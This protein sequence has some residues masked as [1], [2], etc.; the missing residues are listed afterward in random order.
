MK[1]CVAIVGPTASGKSGFALE[2]AA[3]LN[4]EILC[5]DSTT[6]YRGFDIGS[7]KPSKED[8]AKIKHH[9]L[10]VCEPTEPF[11]AYHFVKLAH[12]T[13]TEIQNRN[14]L[15][16]VVG[17]TY[18]YLKALQH[19]MYA[20]TPIPAEVIENIERE[21]FEDEILNTQK[22]HAELKKQDAE[23][24]KQVHPN[25]RYR[26]VRALAIL[27][28][29]KE[30]PSQLKVE[31]LSSD[32][33]GRYWLKYGMCLSRHTLN[34][35]IVRR[36]E[37]M[38]QQGLVEETKG[39]LEKH[40]QS[41]PLQSIGY[42]EAVQFLGRKITEK[43][44]RNEIIEKTRQLAKRQVTWLRSDPEVRYIDF[45]DLARVELEVSNLTFAVGG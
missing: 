19:G 2:L 39:L 42:A 13:I 30:K 7:S 10:D 28:T 8:Q 37:K 4:G 33:K 43:Q 1:I 45:R 15:P 31:P 22:M 32:Q 41:R 40:P 27:R 20:T 11:S 3:K 9:L 29:S 21:F 36:A 23:A 34:Q 12:E 16:I 26:L 25:D 5:M 18:F 17:G 35:A 6:V 38:I 24:A 14:K 44:L